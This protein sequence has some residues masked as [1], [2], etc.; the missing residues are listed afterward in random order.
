MKPLY[1]TTALAVTVAMSAGAWAVPVS[2]GVASRSAY[3]FGG[4]TNITTANNPDASTPIIDADYS[5]TGGPVSIA[6][7]FE[8]YTGLDSQG[9]ER[10]MTFT[11]SGSASAGFGVLR[12]AATGSVTDAFFNNANDP[13]YDP[14]VGINSDG[15]PDYFSVTSE[16]KFTDQLIYGGTAS[17]YTSTYYLH[18]TGN[19]IGDGS[20]FVVV[21]MDHGVNGQQSS[22]MFYTDG[23]YDI[24]IESQA[25]VSSPNQQ[26]SIR[27]FTSFQTSMEYA[28]DGQDYSGTANFANTLD[29]VGVSVQDND[30][31]LYLNQGD[32]SSESGTTYAIKTPAVTTA[33]PEP[34]SISLL[35]MGGLLMLSRR[36]RVM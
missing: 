23:A 2:P 30:T 27:L 14:N 8:S 5:N 33:V 7:F 6:P 22:Q 29:L 18:L 34:A 3:T 15:V 17:N 13:Y 9:D 20:G 10:T 32:I 36:R 25:F 11:G 12:A 24:L 4:A 26:F 21:E 19:I 16:A 35:A 28:N 31:G 1:F